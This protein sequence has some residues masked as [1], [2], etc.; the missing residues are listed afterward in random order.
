L[1]RASLP[2]KAIHRPALLTSTLVVLVG[3][4]HLEPQLTPVNRETFRAP[5]SVQSQGVPRYEGSLFTGENRR[6][7]LFVDR[8][9]HLVNDVVTI[10][11]TESAS[12]SGAATTATDRT[13]S[14][15]GSAKSLFG[16]EPTL[17]NN[18]V[19]L[20]ALEANL[21]NVFDGSGATS[22]KNS[23]SATITAV[24]REVFPNGN[25]YIEGAKEVI[26]NTER[27]YI[28]ISG[29]IRPEDIGPDNSI[30]S[31]LIADAHVEYSG[32]GVLA[33]KQRPGWLG[34]ILDFVWPF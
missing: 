26:I 31:S 21:K 13:S 6:S 11:I 30:P 12:A 9:A 1:S 22:R 14:I 18:G 19:N 3:C 20:T 16:F 33:D 15:S 27:Q 25:L 28:L 5:Q 10:R 2:S 17:K 23:L 8:K 29:V 7:L 24:V 4:A 32:R 34:R